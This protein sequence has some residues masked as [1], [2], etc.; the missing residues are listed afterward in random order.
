VDKNKNNFYC[1]FIYGLVILASFFILGKICLAE[2][3]LKITNVQYTGGPGKT[4]EDFIEITNTT[5]KEIKL[6]GYRLVKKASTGTKTSIKSF[7]SKDII[8]AKEIYLWANTSKSSVISEDNGIAIILG[9]TDSGIIIDSINWEEDDDSEEEEKPNYSGIKIN[10]IYPA[11]DTKNGEEEFVEIINSSGKEIDFSDWVIKDSKGTKGKISKHE[12]NGNFY[13]FYGSFSLNNDSNGDTV[14]LHDKNGNLVDSQKYSSTKSAHSFSFDGS[15]WRWTSLSTPG[16]ENS[17]DKILSGKIILPKKIYKNTYAYFDVLADDDAKK[18]TWNFGDDHKSYLK[19]TKHKYEKTGKYKGSLKITGDGEDKVYE[20]EVKVEKYN[21]PKIR[22]KSISPNPKGSDTKNEWIEIKNES[23]DKINLK[24]WSIATGKEKL[25]NHPIREDFKIKKGKTKKLT[26]KICAF[27]LG[28][29]KTKIELRDP[30]GKVVQKIK[31][32]RKK[33]K[34]AEDEIYEKNKNNKWVW[35]AGNV[36]TPNLGFSTT[37]INK[38]ATPSLP[39]EETNFNISASEIQT[40]LGKY[41]LSSD[42]QKRQKNR[43]KLA[44]S[45]HNINLPEKLLDQN[46][47]V[48]GAENLRFQENFYT[49]TKP[50]NKKHWALNFSE[51]IWT[52]T[53]SFLNYLI[54]KI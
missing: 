53:N 43:Q 52:K 46:K 29:E 34:I 8:P 42:W 28:N 27:T 16:G 3:V 17:F 2:P 21:A 5:D 49:F 48:L 31:Y 44:Y 15:S 32:D 50:E 12:K 14:F 11:P 30:S 18:F 23:K 7:G 19:K 1:F 39:Q 13:V 45:S 24:N 4:E 54:L 25:V 36:E 51:N 40:N 20:F 41:S 37:E 33:D 38:I 35:N 9:N 10:E 26:K 47:R 6:D 22:I